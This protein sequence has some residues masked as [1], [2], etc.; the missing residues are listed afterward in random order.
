MSNAVSLSK[1][2]ISITLVLCMLLCSALAL[3]AEKKDE[4]SDIWLQAQLVTSYT[5]NRHLN[6]FDVDVDVTDGIAYLSGI[7]DSE[8]ERDL[9][10]EI[11]RGIDGIKDVKENLLVEPQVKEKK[12]EKQDKNSFRQKVEDATLTAKVKYRL[13]LNKHTDSFDI[14]VDTDNAVVTLSGKVDDEEKKELALKLAENT[15]HVMEVKDNLTISEKMKSGKKQS[16][17]SMG[18]KLRICLKT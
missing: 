2:N 17:F 10:V 16:D 11:A 7:V 4:K 8:I 3:G 9:A 15:S 18:E 1:L 12:K 13:M 6:S 14:N 5:L